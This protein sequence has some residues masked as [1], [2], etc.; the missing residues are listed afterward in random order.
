[1]GIRRLEYKPWLACVG[2]ATQGLGA[3]TPGYHDSGQLENSSPLQHRL[4]S[5]KWPS[6]AALGN[7]GYLALA[8]IFH[9]T[10]TS[11]VFALGR[12][13]LFPGIFDSNGVG[14]FASDSPIYLAD[15]VSLIN[16]LKQ[17]GV[18][19][20]ASAPF[21]LHTKLYSLV[22]AT[23]GP[24]VGFNI[25]A[26]EPLNLLC[27]L[28]IVFLVFKLGS[29]ISD[30]RTG[31]LAAILVGVWPTFLLHTTQILK[32]PLFIALLL[33]LIFVVTCWLT[34]SFTR[35][36]GLWNGLLGGGLTMLLWFVKPDLWA[37]TLMV[38]L[39]SL[40]FQ[41]LRSIR[42]KKIA[43]GNL[44]GGSALLVIAFGVPLL[45]PR[46][47][48]PY[49]N[50]SPHPF[51]T[52]TG[53]G[54]N[55][56]IAAADPTKPLAVKE[57]SRSSDF[58]TRLRERIAWTRYLFVNY[59]GTSSN[60]DEE[61][62]LESWGEVIRYLPRAAE[63]GLLAPFPR[64]WFAAGAQVGRLGRMLSGVEMLMIYILLMLVLWSLW[65]KHD[66]LAIWFLVTI[67]ALSLIVL[68]LVTANV[69]AL[70]RMRYPFWILLI[71]VGVDGALRL[72]HRRTI[73]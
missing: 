33:G 50:P 15:A 6:V 38:I 28:A 69:G 4:T 71:I 13:K 35:A 57:P 19:G 2:A 55:Q 34:R 27:Y 68:G 43:S 18:V 16:Q 31:R 64:M 20:W 29:E 46:L 37:L 40:V 54:A 56:Q 25:L 11:I 51:L 36:R 72:L 10:I 5:S 66:Q 49:H 60:I 67:A 24:L 12:A 22:L 21:P 48:R 39:L 45:G 14:R 47:I 62:R 65:K 70:Y 23:L 7:R 53:S 3:E 58:L 61:V 63:I 41:C 26:A 52:V 17:S 1:M 44:I 32:D 8:G 73:H 59:P 30:T 42:V 9:L